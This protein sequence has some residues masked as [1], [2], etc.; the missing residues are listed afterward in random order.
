MSS[1]KNFV[2]S[3]VRKTKVLAIAMRTDPITTGLGVGIQLVAFGVGLWFIIQAAKWS[4]ITI[5][6]AF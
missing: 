6:S 2:E 1:I 3:E 4:F 5:T